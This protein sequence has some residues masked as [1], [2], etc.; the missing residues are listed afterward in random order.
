MSALHKISS[1]HA[2]TINTIVQVAWGLLLSRYNNTGDVVFGSVVSGRPPGIYGIERMVGLFI[3]TIPVRIQY[4]ASDELAALM[5]QVQAAALESEQHQYHPLPEIQ[6]QSQ[7][8]R[9]LLDH[10]IVFENFP[11]T[12]AIGED[13]SVD[14]DTGY[15]VSDLRVFEQTNYDLALMVLPHGQ[16]LEM[17]IDYNASRFDPATVETVLAQLHRVIEQVI[18]NSRRPVGDISLITDPERSRILNQF[19]ATTAA[20]PAQETII[21]LFEKQVAQ[22]PDNIAFRFAASSMTYAELNEL[23]SRIACWLHQAHYVQRGHLVGVMMEREQYLLPAIYGILKAGAAYV[24]IDPH[25][26][27]ERISSIIE[28][29]QLKL[30]ITREV[31]DQSLTSIL[32]CF[33]GPVPP[34]PSGHDLAYVIYTSGSTGKPKG[35][36]IEH[37]AVVN[38]LN[39]MQ[40]KYQL[41][42]TDVI[43]QKTPIVFDV[44]VWELFWWSFTGA[45]VALLQPGEEK[46]PAAICAAIERYKVSTMHFVPSMLNAFLQTV[47]SEDS[48]PSLRSL[49]QVFASGEA[50]KPEQVRKF[51]NT[52]HRHCGT[53]LINLYGPT[54]ATVDVSY[55]DCH[56]N[57]EE[58]IIPIGKP[59]DNI[60][61]YVMDH[62]GQLAPIGV[63]GELCIAGVGLARGYVGDET[64][65]SQKFVPNPFMRGER[66]YRTGDLV[67]WLNDGNIEFLDRIDNQVKIRGFRIELGE[68]EHQLAK[69]PLITGTAVVARTSGAEKYL[70][71]Y[72]V[73]QN[74]IDQSALM[75]FLRDKLPVYMMPAQ[76]VHLHAMPLSVNGKLN[77]KALPDPSLSTSGRVAASTQVEQVLL[78]IWSE[79]LHT[80]DIAAD[81]DFFR[82]GG[83]SIRAIN[84]INAVFREFG[85]RLTLRAV[86]ENTTIRQL[87]ALIEQQQTEDQAIIPYAGERQSYP[88]SS[89]QERLFFEYLQDKDSLAYNISAAF[90]IRGELDV[91]RLQH[92]CALLV[93]RHEALRTSFILSG[94]GVVQLIS[95]QVDIA[96]EMPERRAGFIR[97]FDLGQAPLIRFALVQEN[98]ARILLADV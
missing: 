46:E 20:Y 53:A 91:E 45:S 25:F 41:T 98:G 29:A 2:V 56:F 47:E 21:S 68:I 72:Y 61:L 62:A 37:H 74:E 87:A 18:A 3:N 97:P 14:K 60:S 39:W 15:A 23:S 95:K 84:V 55:Y 31:L 40:R 77:R 71:A 96:I 66:M 54:E 52:I 59:I 81:D 79:I 24:P 10:I 80:D 26:P 75:Q 51:G 69:H 88:A 44:S 49:R 50:L 94:D 78:N 65:T 42:P 38:R 93:Q 36:M 27:A 58:D 22:T 33:A 70:V 8:G 30:V 82:L 6:A 1:E 13:A 19:N 73:S 12:D 92:A 67:R 28:S 5:K 16:Q 90:E 34:K 43:L 35:V 32:C 11:M 57:E 63:P 4:N 9:A 7:A 86:F 83:H 85:V 64:L 89:A 76:F 17:K 48:Y